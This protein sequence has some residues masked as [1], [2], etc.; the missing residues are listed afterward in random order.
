LPGHAYWNLSQDGAFPAAA[1][2]AAGDAGRDAEHGTLRQRANWFGPCLNRAVG[3]AAASAFLRLDVLA[4]A[5]GSVIDL[6][7]QCS[8][9]AAHAVSRLIDAKRKIPAIATT[10][11]ALVAVAAVQVTAADSLDHHDP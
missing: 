11:G 10:A 9:S 6:Y 3:L 1:A 4:L 7:I 8:L 2:A 5:L